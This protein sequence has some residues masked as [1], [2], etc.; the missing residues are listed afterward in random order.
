MKPA[1]WFIVVLLLLGVSS[2]ILADDQ[3]AKGPEV[4]KFQMGDRTLPFKHWLHQKK[5]KG[6]NCLICHPDKIG[7]IPDLGKD[8]AHA[9]CLPCHEVM[10]KGPAACK[11][12]HYGVISRN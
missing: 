5:I 9:L 12:C 4:I 7:K 6:N 3:S 8:K 1:I 2:T 10:N 11:F